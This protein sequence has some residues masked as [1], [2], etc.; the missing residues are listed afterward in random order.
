MPQNAIVDSMNVNQ[1]SGNK[2]RNKSRFP[3]GRPC[4][5]TYRFAE[6]G[7]SDC[8]EV[9]PDDKV[10]CRPVQ[11]VQTYTLGAPLLQDINLK[12]DAFFVPMEAILPNNWEKFFV[13]PVKGD[14]VPDDVNCCVKDFSNLLFQFFNILNQYVSG[15]TSFNQLTYDIKYLILL[16]MFYSSGCLM[17][18]LGKHYS[19]NFVILGGAAQRD[20]HQHDFGLYFDTCIAN[21]NNMISS[22][23]VTIQGDSYTVT[24]G[25]TGFNN[26]LSV[27]DF[28][29]I[30]RD[31]F[32]WNITAVT[33]KAGAQLGRI[34]GTFG[35]TY[36]I[37]ALS[38]EPFNFAR[39][40]AYQIACAHFYTNDKIDYVFSAQLYRQILKDIFYHLVDECGSSV[41]PYGVGFFSVNSLSYEYDLLSGNV[42]DYVFQHVLSGPGTTSLVFEFLRL[43]FG[44]NNSLRF[45]DYF[46]G[47]RSQPLA[48]GDVDVAVN[49]NMVNVIDITENILR[50]KFFNAVNRVGQRI[51]NYTKELFGVEMQKDFHN[52][53]WLFHTNTHVSGQNTEN[54]GAAQVDPSNPLAVTSRM[55]GSSGSKTFNF[56]ADRA[57]IVIII[58]YFDLTRLY[59]RST[60]RAFFHENR[61]DMFNPYL[62]YA[63]DQPIYQDELNSSLPHAQ[64]FGYTGHYM[65]YKQ[66]VPTCFGGVRFNLPGMVFVDDYYNARSRQNKISP[67]FIRSIPTELDRYYKSLTGYS[68][69]S[70]FH[71][72]IKNMND[73]SAVRP[74]AYNPGILNG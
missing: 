1:T 10:Y 36:R 39:L 13:N 43:L 62:Q 37:N 3:L 25:A 55:F 7:I 27:R 41:S 58:N 63:G 53:F 48:V 52:P 34:T 59:C 56:S 49:N 6:Y 9:V 71:F 51:E 18:A 57:G 72:I 69:D 35:T 4:V 66:R 38:E 65:E 45:Q 8:F 26:N 74:M 21:L 73:I 60:D 54:T 5:G 61:F 2:V 22:M 31:T 33:L 23:T 67:S 12:Q 11:E 70:Y 46:T 68:L 47:A 17:S 14:D 24:A 16:E 50:Q 19:E 64:Y 32:D 28:L 20:N 40:A 44:Y 15:L 30:I 29:C 42:I